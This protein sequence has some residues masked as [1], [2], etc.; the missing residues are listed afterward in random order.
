MSK[1]LSER[2]RYR[3]E[4]LYEKGLTTKEIATRIGL[5]YITVY[6][7]TRL[8]KRIN[9]E[10][11]KPFKSGTEYDNYITRQRINPE[12]NEPFESKLEYNHYKEI[13]RMSRRENKYFGSFITKRIKA[14]GINQYILAAEV[15]ITR[16]AINNYV[17]GRTLPTRK[18]FNKMLSALG[19]KNKP[20]ILENLVLTQ[21]LRL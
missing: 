10:T 13:E 6:R 17:K 21:Y 9:P 16:Q 19:V 14:L 20:K 11:N 5:S 4:S 15:G 18:N 8:K 1:I 2:L 7:Q 3:I 12:T